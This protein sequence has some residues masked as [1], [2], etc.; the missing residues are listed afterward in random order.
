MSD[1]KIAQDQARAQI[2]LDSINVGSST[3][4]AGEGGEDVAIDDDEE[5]DAEDEANDED[6][7]EDLRKDNVGPEVGS[8]GP[9]TTAQFVQ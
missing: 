2:E 8:E 4:Q 7:V 6:D 3:L 5:E 9:S 1:L